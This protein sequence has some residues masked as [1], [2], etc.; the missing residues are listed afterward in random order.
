MPENNH[1]YAVLVD[2]GCD[3][4]EVVFVGNYSE[5]AQAAGTIPDELAI[6]VQAVVPINE[7]RT[8]VSTA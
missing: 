4:P 7:T 5:V 8:S 2:V 1:H 6:S 3:W